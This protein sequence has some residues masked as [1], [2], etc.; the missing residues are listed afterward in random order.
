MLANF[1]FDHHLE[2]GIYYM[3]P[4]TILFTVNIAIFIYLVMKKAFASLWLE[5]FRH[6]GMLILVY[7][8]F[9]TLAG[10]IQMFDALESIKE[11][12]PRQVISGGVKVA[13][14]TAFYGTVYFCITQATY[15]ALRIFGRNP[16]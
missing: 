7:G 4:L 9:G 3:M 8:I 6:I 14:I 15:I 16:S 1:F 11:D 13:L 12:L 5:V 2:G 10:F